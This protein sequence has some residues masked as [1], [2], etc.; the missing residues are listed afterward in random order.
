MSTPI[1]LTVQQT[2]VRNKVENPVEGLSE[3]AMLAIAEMSQG[4]THNLHNLPHNESAM[5]LI[6]NWQSNNSNL[7]S[8]LKAA[9][10]TSG[11]IV[12]IARQLTNFTVLMN[13]GI[14]FG[15]HMQSFLRGQ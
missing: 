5:D 11:E 12:D 14:S 6:S 13:S 3:K 9:M 4:L 2:P 1:E 7:N 15:K 10:T 8:E